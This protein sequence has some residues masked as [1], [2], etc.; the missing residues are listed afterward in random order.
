VTIEEGFKNYAL[1][2]S[3]FQEEAAE[4]MNQLQK[5][6][7]HISNFE[8]FSKK[9]ILPI[10][11][12]FL[13]NAS[14][15]QPETEEIAKIHEKY[16]KAVRLNYEVLSAVSDLANGNVD[17][18]TKLSLLNKLEMSQNLVND[19]NK[20]MVDL[21]KKYNVALPEIKFDLDNRLIRLP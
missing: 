4:K 10:A 18:T 15:I 21:S 8:Q 1:T 20:S 5:E 12:E 17:T 13:D 19:W 16:M 2:V 11:K 14:A 6:V 9:R 3:R 7:T